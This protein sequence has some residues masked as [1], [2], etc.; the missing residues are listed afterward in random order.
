MIDTPFVR[1]VAYPQFWNRV[2]II[3]ALVSLWAL[4]LEQLSTV[5]EMLAEQN[6]TATF[7]LFHD[8][9]EA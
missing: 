3:G 4:I 6:D 1:R 7:A 5:K 2:E 9:M 8:D